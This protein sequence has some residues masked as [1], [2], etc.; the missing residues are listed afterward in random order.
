MCYII[1]EVPSLL[2][3][4]KHMQGRL[5]HTVTRQT[6]MCWDSMFLH[7]S[8]SIIGKAF[9]YSHPS[10]NLL[11]TSLLAVQEH[12]GLCSWP[13][14]TSGL[15]TFR[16][17]NISDPHHLVST[18]HPRRLLNTSCYLSPFQPGRTLNHLPLFHI[19]FQQS[20]QD[21]KTPSIFRITTNPQGFNSFLY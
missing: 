13:N 10:L 17:L 20:I 6:A 16:G 2:L 11:S 15:T 1:L 19:L 21:F 7:S 18:F 4:Q 12:Y 3:Q 9:D 8:K 14:A 5:L